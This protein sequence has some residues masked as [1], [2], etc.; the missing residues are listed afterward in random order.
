MGV[1][2]EVPSPRRAASPVQGFLIHRLSE[3]LFYGFREAVVWGFAEG[4]PCHFPSIS[5]SASKP[6]LG[7]VPSRLDG[8]GEAWNKMGKFPN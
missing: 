3:K 7:P 5:A 1:L 4:S 6:A 8:K 2:I